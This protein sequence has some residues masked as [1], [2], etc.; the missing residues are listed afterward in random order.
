MVKLLLNANLSHESAEFLETL[1]YEAK[2]VAQ[3]GLAKKTDQKIA[4]FAQKKGYIII[5]HDMDFGE[6]YFLSPNFSL[7]VVILKLPNQTI[8]EVN[9]ALKHITQSKI[10]ELMESNKQILVIYDKGRFRIRKK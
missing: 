10:F 9:K 4:R 7:R 2:T 1:G 5:T 3:F 8:E 6:M